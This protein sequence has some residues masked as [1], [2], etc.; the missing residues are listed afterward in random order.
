MVANWVRKISQ[1]PSGR[2]T[3]R[4]A[5]LA[6]LTDFCDLSGAISSGA[7]TKENGPAVHCRAILGML[8]SAERIRTSDL[9]VMSPVNLEAPLKWL[10]MALG[11]ILRRFAVSETDEPC[12]P[13]F[14]CFALR[15]PAGCLLRW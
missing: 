10:R 12:E 1:G 4:S 7:I 15:E 13:N 14:Q 5:N 6:N 3:G 2:W 8:G 9:K 11:G